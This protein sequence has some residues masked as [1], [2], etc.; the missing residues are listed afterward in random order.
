MTRKVSVNVVHVHYS[1]KLIFSLIIGLL[2]MFY[3]MTRDLGGCPLKV[4][5]SILSID[6]GTL[7]IPDKK[8]FF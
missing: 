7:M 4:I 5:F 1:Y 3:P 2:P 6:G 8:M